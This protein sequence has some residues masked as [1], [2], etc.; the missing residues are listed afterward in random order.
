MTR[1]G[2]IVEVS[3]NNY[4]EG[5]AYDM[6]VMEEAK[7][8]YENAKAALSTETSVKDENLVGRRGEN[9]TLAYFWRFRTELD[10]KRKRNSKSQ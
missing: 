1:E 9:F 7:A 5:L 8:G 4:F 10:G 3:F 2:K 6:R